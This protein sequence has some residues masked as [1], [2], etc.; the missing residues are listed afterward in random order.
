M[1][2]LER[3][4][5]CP[6]CDTSTRA[7][8]RTRHRPHRGQPLLSRCHFSRSVKRLKTLSGRAAMRR[9]GVAVSVGVADG[10]MRCSRSV[11]PLR[12][13]G[14][15]VWLGAPR[16]REVLGHRAKHLPVRP[17][18]P[19]RPDFAQCNQARVPHGTPSHRC[20]GCHCPRDEAHTPLAP[21]GEGDGPLPAP[22]TFTD[23][24]VPIPVGPCCTG[25]SPWR[26]RRVRREPA[27]PPRPDCA[28]RRFP[29]EWPARPHRR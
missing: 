27:C 5:D 12:R 1:C 24:L 29:C 22:G 28:A 23:P 10:V 4:G 9:P 26:A 3:T 17:L 11:R 6:G 16:A 25:F 13:A 20:P 18:E 2:G 19:L 7:R 15:G 8:R 14:Q 21:G